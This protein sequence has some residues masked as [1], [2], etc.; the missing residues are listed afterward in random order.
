M[1][2]NNGVTCDQCGQKDFIGKRYKCK[3]CVNFDLCTK[4]SK[5]SNFTKPNH[6][7]THGLVSCEPTSTD[8]ARLVEASLTVGKVKFQKFPGDVFVAPFE[9]LNIWIDCNPDSISVIAQHSFGNLSSTQ[10]VRVGEYL[11][12][13]NYGI[14]LGCFTLDR[15]DGDLRFVYHFSTHGSSVDELITDILSSFSVCLSTWKR[16]VDRLDDVISG[17]SPRDIIQQVERR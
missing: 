7:R 17:V 3:V 6:N 9:N 2:V 8:L 1:N 11:T 10:K 12:R 16:Y 14:L 4:C 15:D 5:L 13:A